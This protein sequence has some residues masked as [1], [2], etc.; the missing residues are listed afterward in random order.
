M[1]AAEE[2]CRTEDGVSSAANARRGELLH[3]APR[4]RPVEEVDVLLEGARRDDF[5]DDGRVELDEVLEGDLGSR[6][7]C[8][9]SATF[10]AERPDRMSDEPWPPEPMGE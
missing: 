1:A 9:P 8:G 4:Q 6:S 7:C 5:V 10:V 3:V 2:G